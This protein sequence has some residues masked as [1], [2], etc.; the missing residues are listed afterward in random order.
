MLRYIYTIFRGNTVPIGAST[1]VSYWLRYKTH[2]KHRDPVHFGL[3]Y[4]LPKGTYIIL[5]H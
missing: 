5:P 3:W 2:N 4:I 1:T